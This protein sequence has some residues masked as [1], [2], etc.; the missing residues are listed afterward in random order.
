MRLSKTGSTALR[1]AEVQQPK[2]TATLSLE[3]SFLDFSA[4]VGQSEAPSS[5]I[6]SSFIFMTPPAALISSIAIRVASRTEVSE[7]AIVPLSEW[8]TPTLMVPPVLAAAGAAAFS[9]GFASAAWRRGGARQPPASRPRRASRLVP[10]RR[11]ARRPRAA[12]CRPSGSVLPGGSDV[13]ASAACFQ[14]AG[15]RSITSKPLLAIVRAP[16][17]PSPL[18]PRRPSIGQPIDR[19]GVADPPGRFPVTESVGVRDRSILWTARTEFRTWRLA[20]CTMQSV[21]PLRSE[22]KLDAADSLVE[23]RRACA[24]DGSCLFAAWAQCPSS[25]GGESVGSPP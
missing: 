9:A 22:M 25:M 7:I 13:A 24:R 3:I 2:T 5:T 8:S 16:T 4:K 20:H 21:R 6:G 15:S 1:L 10:G 19:F 12:R 18:T 17:S 23:N 11:P 14:Y